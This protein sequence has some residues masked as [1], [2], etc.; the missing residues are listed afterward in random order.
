MKK[1]L[2]ALAALT[3]A[4]VASNGHAADLPA[5]KTPPAA[6]PTPIWKGFYVGLNAGGNW[7]NDS[8]IS[9]N[10][11]PVGSLAQGNAAYWAMGNRAISGSSQ[12]GFLGGGQVGYNWQP[13]LLNNNL[14][15]GFEADIQGVAAGNGTR[16]YT[17]AY[18]VGNTSLIDTTTANSQLQFLGTV[19]GR[20]GYLAT[21]TLLVYGTGGVAYGGVSFNATNYVNA[22]AAS[23]AQ[24]WTGIGST[25]ASDVNVGYAAGGGA[26]WMFMPNW[27]A[28][29]E[30][31]YYNLGNLNAQLNSALYAMS[32][33]PASQPFRTTNLSGQVNGNVVRLGVNYHFSS[34]PK[35]VVAKF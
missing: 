2:I 1:T 3:P 18:T 15:F 11:Y 4:L 12:G 10:T 24:T 35:P 33:S 16:N 14:I 17:T 22:F 6:L 13:G 23:G 19:R 29:A 34:A 27:S 8:S 21:P 30:Y 28:K 25:S 9:A 32:A 26:E 20:V 5:M 7:G 31:L